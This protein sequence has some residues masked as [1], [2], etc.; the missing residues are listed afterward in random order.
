MLLISFFF[1]PSLCSL[2]RTRKKMVI[3]PG[4]KSKTLIGSLHVCSS[5]ELLPVK[6]V[7]K[8][9]PQNK[10]NWT[11]RLFPPSTVAGPTFPVSFVF[12]SSSS[13]ER[14]Y[15]RRMLLLRTGTAIACANR[16]LFPSLWQRQLF[17]LFL[18]LLFLLMNSLPAARPFRRLIN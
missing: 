16:F 11:Q 10:E 4:L 14:G 1:S 17:Y 7:G 18:V 9:S 6:S 12:S 8:L 15:E 2:H 3:T 13:K 5:C